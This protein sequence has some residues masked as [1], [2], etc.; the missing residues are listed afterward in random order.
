MRAIHSPRSS[1]SPPCKEG[2][3]GG[4]ECASTSCEGRHAWPASEARLRLATHPQPLP[5]REGSVQALHTQQVITR[6]RALI[7]VR[8][9]P[10]GRDPATG[11]DCVGLAG[12]AMGVPVPTGYALRGAS[13]GAVAALV[14]ATGLLRRPP[15]PGALLLVE[16]GPAQCHLLV[17]TDEGFVHAD[18]GRRRVV[19]R[20]G[21]AEWPTVGSWGP[22]SS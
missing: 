2:A 9:R 14:D 3:G 13:P 17:L 22:L 16:S 21:R 15:A 8:F 19:E 7:G 4:C 1:Y 12:L 5:V 11:L 18:A 10:H 20:R 6:A